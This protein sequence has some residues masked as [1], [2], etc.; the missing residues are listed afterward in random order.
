LISAGFRT[1]L[2]VGVSTWREAVG[3]G[4]TLPGWWY[5]VVSLPVFQFLFWRWN[6]RLLLWW[7][8]IWRISRLDLQLIPTHP[9]L[10]GGLGGFGVAHVDLAPLGLGF[11][12]TVITTY[13]EHMMVSGVWHNSSVLPITSVVVGV[14]LTILAPLAIFMPRLLEVKQRGLLDY[15][16]LAAD[17]ARALDMKW[18]GGKAPADETMLGT[19]DIQSL[20]DL[21]NSFG[22]IRSMRIVPIAWSQIVMIAAAA[23][24]PTV[25]L[26]V[27]LW[28][29]D[30]L[31][32]HGVRTI[33]SI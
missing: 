8:L 33:L 4:L 26:A 24:L 7:Q 28:P 16:A 29:L 1:D 11:T 2:P 15:G 14:T 3:G 5:T 21:A 30:E 13:A 9:D 31:I 18:I 17:Y 22:I 23:A 32:V 25:L 6:W 12:S 19:A 20:A 10:S 27:V